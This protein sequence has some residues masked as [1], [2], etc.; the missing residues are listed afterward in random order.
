MNQRE[1]YR[2]HAVR[3]PG[4]ER[5][6]LRKFAIAVGVSELLRIAV[7]DQVR[8]SLDARLRMMT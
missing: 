3:A 1:C 6:R 2:T 7:E 5:E 8:R 4:V